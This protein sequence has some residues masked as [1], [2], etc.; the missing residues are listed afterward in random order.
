MWFSKILNQGRLKQIKGNRE[1]FVFKADIL[2]IYNF[3]FTTIL[4]VHSDFLTAFQEQCS[5][6]LSSFRR[7]WYLDGGRQNIRLAVR[8]IRPKI[9]F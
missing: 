9:L 3:F 6:K 1:T 8:N 7:G 2:I 4:S 5:L